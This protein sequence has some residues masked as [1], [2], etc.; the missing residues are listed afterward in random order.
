MAKEKK[1]FRQKYTEKLDSATYSVKTASPE[2]QKKADSA[3]RSAAN[4]AFNTDSTQ[5]R[6]R[7]VSGKAVAPKPAS[8]GRGRGVSGKAVS[9][10]APGRARGVSSPVKATTPPK[11]TAKPARDVP[12]PVSKPSFSKGSTTPP[13][14]KPDSPQKRG[15]V[16]SGFSGNWQGAAP[17]EM[18]KRGGARVNHGG[19]LFGKK[20]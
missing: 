7:G 12:K 5:G 4:T 1:S 10:A 3:A 20:K 14:Y 16:T 11:P 18:Q 9:P 13:A 6:G 15:N 19:G 2:S 8:P 17:T